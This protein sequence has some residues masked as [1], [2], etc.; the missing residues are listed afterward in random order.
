MVQYALSKG[1][2]TRIA[3]KLSL[4]RELLAPSEAMTLDS[5]NYR[6]GNR[7][8]ALRVQQ[9]TFCHAHVVDVIVSHRNT[10]T[11]LQVWLI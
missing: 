7:G 1:L 11:G 9:S 10:R 4:L 6:Y 3:N 8:G 2:A 5:C